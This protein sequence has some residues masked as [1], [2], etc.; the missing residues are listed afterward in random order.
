MLGCVAPRRPEDNQVL[1]RAAGAEEDGAG[2]S[3]FYIVY[4][5][6]SRQPQDHLDYDKQDE[7]CNH[8]RHDGGVPEVL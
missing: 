5:P 1:K 2:Q 4:L 7:E 3:D 6:S 8:I